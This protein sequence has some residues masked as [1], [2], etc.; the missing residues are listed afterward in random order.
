MSLLCLVMSEVWTTWHVRRP[1]DVPT[2]W[3]INPEK[4]LLL[5]FIRDPKSL[6]RNPKVITKLWFSSL[7]LRPIKLKNIRL[8]DLNGA[9]ETWNELLENGWESIDFEY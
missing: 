1:L 6:M 4:N 3:L 5:C 7:E 8:L 9:V 2:G